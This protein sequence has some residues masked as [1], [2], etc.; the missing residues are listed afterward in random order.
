MTYP[1]RPLTKL[2]AIGIVKRGKAGDFYR[3]GYA[4]FVTTFR[5]PRKLKSFVIA[6]NFRNELV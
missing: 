2:E 4:Y 6:N 1:K 5:K 3:K